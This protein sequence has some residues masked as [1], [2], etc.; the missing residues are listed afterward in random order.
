[1]ISSV[2]GVTL[3]RVLFIGKIRIPA[4]LKSLRT[5]GIRSL[6]VEGGARIIQSFLAESTHN[7][8]MRAVNAV[9]VTVAPIFVGDDGVG[10]GTNVSSSAVSQ[11]HVISPDSD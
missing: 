5:L 2:S 1:M 4:L 11:N 3:T 7:D 6:M 8:T 10:Y 9:V